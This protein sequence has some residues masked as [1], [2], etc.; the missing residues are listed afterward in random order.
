MAPLRRA[1]GDITHCHTHPSD[2]HMR[3]TAL[4]RIWFSTLIGRLMA[5]LIRLLLWSG[6]RL[7]LWADALS[8]CSSR[9]QDRIAPPTVLNHGP[10]QRRRR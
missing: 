10:G 5:L 4:P 9:L 2:R 1:I 8:V 3:P 7:L 6:G